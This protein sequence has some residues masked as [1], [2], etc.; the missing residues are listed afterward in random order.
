MAY[1]KLGYGVLEYVC[2]YDE[3]YFRKIMYMTNP[4][5]FQMDILA[6]RK[7]EMYHLCGPGNVL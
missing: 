4:I 2:S 7:T 3:S 6:K 5:L 1:V